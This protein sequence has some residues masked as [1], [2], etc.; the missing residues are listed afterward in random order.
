MSPLG[1]NG[2]GYFH[3]GPPLTLAQ[4]HL[5]DMNN[6]PIIIP[7]VL[8]MERKVKLRC[9]IGSSEA[10][11]DATSVGDAQSHVTLLEARPNPEPQTLSLS[12]T[13]HK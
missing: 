8:A 7:T 5:A 9:G 4:K 1:I 6:F 3:L 12:Q 2:S 10:L 11:S 13:P